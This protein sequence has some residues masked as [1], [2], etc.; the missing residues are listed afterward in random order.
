[1][2]ENCIR[3]VLSLL[4]AGARECRFQAR[5][6]GVARIGVKRGGVLGRPFQEYEPRFNPGYL[7]A[8][9]NEP[10]S[11][12]TLA[13]CEAIDDP[14]EIRPALCVNRSQITAAHGDQLGASERLGNRPTRNNI[15]HSNSYYKNDAAHWPDARHE[16]KAQLSS[17]QLIGIVQRRKLPAESCRR[18]RIRRGRGA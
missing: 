15:E 4:S 16:N 2:N 18:A 5:S 11:G 12:A 13:H 17:F 10:D 3:E 14:E 9:A 7:P 6:Y 8:R 1:M